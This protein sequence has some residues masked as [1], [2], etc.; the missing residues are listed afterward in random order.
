MSC[1]LQACKGISEAE[2][3]AYARPLNTSAHRAGAAQWPLL[4][5]LTTHF[6]AAPYMAAA[7]SFL[8]TW[9]KPCLVMFSERCPVTSGTCLLALPCRC[10]AAVVPLL[11][12]CCAPCPVTSGTCTI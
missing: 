7:H 1:G 11:C 2:A 3:A 10:C 12:P 6:D 5:P 9:E 4:V 8:K